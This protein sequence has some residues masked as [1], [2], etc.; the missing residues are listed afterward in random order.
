MDHADASSSKNLSGATWLRRRHLTARFMPFST[1]ARIYP[2]RPLLGQRDGT[3]H[4]I[5]ALRQH[6]PG[7]GVEPPL[8]GQR[9]NHRRRKRVAS[10]PPRRLL[11]STGVLRDMFQNHLLQLLALVANGAARLV[12]RRLR[13][14]RKGQSAERHPAH[15]PIRH[16]ARPISRLLRPRPTSRPV[17]RRRPTARSNCS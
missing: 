17:R 4:L 6:H 2:H 11:R 9:A 7:A 16:A 15:T 8:R 5:L 3:E 1:K 10:G 12:Q 14:Q 13:A